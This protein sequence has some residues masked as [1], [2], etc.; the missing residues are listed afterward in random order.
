MEDKKAQRPLARDRKERLELPVHD[1]KG[2]AAPT[3]DQVHARQRAGE[4]IAK[5]AR[6][7]RGFPDDPSIA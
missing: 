6:W 7:R 2:T 4:I 5:S 3:Y 1:W